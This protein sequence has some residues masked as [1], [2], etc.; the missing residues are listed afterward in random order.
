VRWKK[1]PLPTAQQRCWLPIQGLCLESGCTED[2]LRSVL[3]RGSV[4]ANTPGGFHSC[5]DIMCGCR[6]FVIASSNCRPNAG[7]WTCPGRLGREL[8]NSSARTGLTY[9]SSYGTHDCSLRRTSRQVSRHSPRAIADFGV[10]HFG[11][12]QP[13]NMIRNCF[14]RR[15]KPDRGTTT[16]SN[17]SRVDRSRVLNV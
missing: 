17:A 5:L 11:A 13:Q 16:V 15:A 12:P 2:S 14:Q 1:R 8:K 3:R 10:N 7:C 4:A 6:S 9:P